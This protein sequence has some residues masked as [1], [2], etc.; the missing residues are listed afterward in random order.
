MKR[1]AK[2]LKYKPE[3]LE[4]VLANLENARFVVVDE[5]EEELLV[6]SFLRNDEVYKQPKVLLAASRQLNEISSAKLRDEVAGEIQRIL[7]EGLAKENTRPT[8]LK[9]LGILGRVA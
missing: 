3:Q 2:K 5:D 6:R 4:K 9:M 7:R 1:W 8:L